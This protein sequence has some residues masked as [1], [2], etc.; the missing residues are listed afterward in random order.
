[1]AALP[2]Q[3]Q[4]P[5]KPA[6]TIR[7]HLLLLALC[8]V[9]PVIAFA[10]YVSVL[11]LEQSRTAIRTGAL[12]RARA[13]ST[14]VDAELRGSIATLN[15]LATSQAL[16]NGDLAAFHEEASRVSSSQRIWRS[17]NLSRASDFQ[18]VMNSARPLGSELNRL[19][20]L[21]SAEQALKTRL[22]AIG[23][24][25]VGRLF[26]TPLVA[27]RIPVAG[28]GATEFILT[29]LVQPRTFEA[30]IRELKV[31][32][33][34]VIAIVD[35]GGK[36]VAR[37]PSVAAGTMS[38]ETFVNA[39]HAEPEGWYRGPSLDGRDTFVTH[40][41]SD[42]SQWTIGLAI[43]AEFVVA[44][45][46]RTVWLLGIGALVSIMLALLIAYL[47]GR[48]I[49]DPVMGLAI[50]ARS[51]GGPSPASV[52]SGGS[53][54]EVAEVAAALAQAS[55][56]VRERQRLVEREK[57]ALLESDRAKDEF[58]AMLSHELRNPLAALTAAAHLLKL[59]G[60]S[61]NA[62]EHARGVIER[63]TRH[64]TRLI[65]DLLD[66]NRVVMGKATLIRETV[67]LGELA[68]EVVRTWR[69]S[70][71]LSRHDVK[72]DAARVVIDA[73]RS[74]I[75]QVFS[76]LLENALKFTP[77]EKKIVVTVAREDGEAV[78]RVADEGI[79]LAPGMADQM[80]GLF[81]QGPQSIDRQ[82]GG[83]GVGLALVKGLVELHGGKVAVFSEGT[84]RGTVFTVRLPLAAAGQ[85]APPVQ[86][87]A[88]ARE[89]ASRNILIVEDNVDARKMLRVMLE[90]SGNRV[91]DA[92]DGENGLRMAAEEVP[93]VM[94]VDIGLPD[95]NGY[96][97][98]AR[99]RAAP[100]GENILLI[101]LTGY[102]Q[103]EDKRR[104]LEAGF[105]AHATKPVLP[106]QLDLLIGSAGRAT[107]DRV[108]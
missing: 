41:R 72:I 47:I 3:T 45:E 92:A 97:I 43:P 93:E 88:P 99:V 4:A 91:R 26:E 20:D 39:M 76:N 46:R 62:S 101:A 87:A 86:S 13:I 105:D 53:V 102:G 104:A 90:L 107:E 19:T 85:A 30:L 77:P 10:F 11:L 38:G 12:E 106:E 32:E 28:K 103:A 89:T 84:G 22:P 14:A 42:F 52:F 78:L 98:A 54:R 66:V 36:F 6:M 23:S 15:A 71:R 68:G 81:V 25:T 80:F 31:P 29:A 55:E 73:D 64:M 1:M 18:Q 51:I 57:K 24:V 8:S 74:R 5:G 27:V 75:E 59:P 50:A 100:W 83:L 79:G 95:L 33:G 94:I 40:L 17:V 67:D 70:G 9:V 48:H 69:Q 56:G 96:E 16:A 65:E 60:A 2:H 61:G 21:A 58:I 37:I 34:W 44:G 82:S 35:R 63:Q 108:G 49:A 7:A